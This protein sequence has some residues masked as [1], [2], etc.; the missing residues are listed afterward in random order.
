M[1]LTEL[2]LHNFGVYRGLHR[3]SLA[4][5]SGRPIV[6]FGGL[7]GAG[8]TTLLEGV[9]LAL[10]GKRTLTTKREGLAYDD[11]LRR[12]IHHSVPASEGASV[13]LRFTLRVAGELRT[14]RISRVWHETP[15][16]MREVQEVHEGNAGSEILNAQL[17]ARWD[18]HVEGVVP[19]GVAPLFFFDGDRIEG[20]ADLANSGEL[21][22]TAVHGLLGLDLIDR[23]SVDLQIL[24]RRKFASMTRSRD[25][26][27]FKI[28]EQLAQR[29]ESEYTGADERVR[30]LEAKSDQID[31]RA[32]KVEERFKRE[33]GELYTQRAALDARLSQLREAAKS[34]EYEMRATASGIA[35]L[36]LVRQLLEEIQAE[37][38]ADQNRA[39][40]AALLEMLDQR[41]RSLMRFAELTAPSEVAL[42]RAISEYLEVDRSKRRRDLASVEVFSLSRDSRASLSTLLDGQLDEVREGIRSQGAEFADLVE[43]I[44]ETER[45]ISGI[46]E[47][48]AIRPLVSELGQARSAQTEMKRVLTKAR[49]ERDYLFRQAEMA[50]RRLATEQKKAIDQKWRSRSARRVVTF[51][52]RSREQLAA[53]RQQV[54]IRN[55]T[56][57]QHLVLE[58]FQQLLRKTGMVQG[59]GIDPDNLTVTL[60]GTGG[61]T[62]HPDR[63]SAGE[64]QLLAVSLLWGLAR[65]SRRVIPTIVD[66][67]LGRLDSV[68]RQ[69]LVTRYFPY[70]GHQVLLLSTDE[71]IDGPYLNALSGHIGQSYHLRYDDTRKST[72]VEKGYF[73]QE[74]VA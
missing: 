48:D 59:L 56:R 74:A 67:P 5:V 50:K 52:S 65:A 1:T 36:L 24:E 46:P 66:T 18:E 9:L 69:H 44:D 58:S 11:Y 35:P 29:A 37:D 31:T 51:S 57:I 4:P 73:R 42:M 25:H 12:C 2:E 63:L 64:R 23:L 68:H 7:N 26:E 20:L 62:L 71:E 16:G 55:L 33:G 19:L 13:R 41:D 39:A 22:R 49:E 21:I 6:L 10:Y 47:E 54:L 53:F 30:R 70:A 45:T 43:Q 40:S 61:H 38:L 27:S 15:S 8:K 72:T 60:Y 14:V 32:N 17:T 28:A 3:I 34:L